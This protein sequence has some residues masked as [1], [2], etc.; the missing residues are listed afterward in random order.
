MVAADESAG[1]GTGVNGALKSLQ[2]FDSSTQHWIGPQDT[3]QGII[4]SD[5]ILFKKYVA[6][7]RAVVR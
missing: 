6:K 7:L 2:V 4:P 5:G 1:R 3:D